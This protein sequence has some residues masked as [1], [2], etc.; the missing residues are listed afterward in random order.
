MWFK[1]KIQFNNGARPDT[2][3]QELKDLDYTQRELVASI[4]P[5]V[6]TK[7]TK[8]RTFPKRMQNGSGSCVMQ[9][10]EKERGII[11][12]LKYGEF[13]VFSCND[14]YQLRANPEI[15]G[16]TYEDLIK[17][18]NRGAVLEILSPSQSLNDLQMMN[19]KKLSYSDDVS[20]IFGAK[21]IN[22]DLNIDTIASTIENTGKG[23]GLTVMFGS[24][25]WFRTDKVKE[26]TTPDK[27]INGH[28]VVAIDYTLDNQGNKCLVIDDSS[29]EDG[30]QYRLVPES[31]LLNRTYWKPNYILNFKQYIEKPE[32]P[33]FDG[34]VKSLQDCLKYEG[35][36]PVNTDS[37]GFF[38]AVTKKALIAFQVKYNIEPAVGFFGDITKAKLRV[39]YP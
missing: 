4:A 19:A 25:E 20:K 30:Y 18:T 31:F 10:L 15:S 33:S 35:L 1:K 7:K 29:C 37:T 5:V 3:P 2:R 26:L 27:W 38:G 17:A 11:A 6:W 34:S 14:D 9:S 28:R 32:K 39:L 12:Q 22:M 24:G 36:F 16:S 23:V 13:I 21:R 8:Y